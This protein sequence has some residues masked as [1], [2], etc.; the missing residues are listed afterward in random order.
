MKYKDLLSCVVGALTS[1]IMWLYGGVSASM[2]CLMIC[3]AVDY[4]LGLLVAGVFKKSKKTE[5]GRLNSM[6]G[7]KG[8]C[9]KGC[10]LMIVAVGYRLDMMLNTVYIRDALITGYIVNE[11]ISI[12]ENCGLMG[13][14]MP[15]AVKNAIDVLNR[16]INEN[17][18]D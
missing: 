15:K 14:P 5:S 13:V 6:E 17:D 11:I 18:L 16:K 3:M 4:I 2:G 12:T 1:A 9:K 8:L 7:W 10:I